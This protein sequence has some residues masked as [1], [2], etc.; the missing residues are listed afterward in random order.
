MAISLQ[1]DSN[2]PQGY[3]LV[4]GTAAATVRQDG[5]LV[6]P[7]L[8]ASGIRVTGNSTFTGT[9]STAGISVNGN[10]S[11]TGT[12][13]VS[14]II[15]NDL[16]TQTSA[17]I[18]SPVQSWQNVAASRTSGATY[19][20]TT[21]RPIMVSAGSLGSGS[22]GTATSATV[23]GVTV[24]NNATQQVNCSTG[25]SFIVPAGAT[26][27]VSATLPWAFFSELR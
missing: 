12:T 27:S 2:L 26:Y 3:I 24:A 20:N 7:S 23:N 10:I 1:A 8:S 19:T 9:L 21:G 5:T 14:G 15:F 16:S 13:S 25:V 22:T 4:N 17:P 6:V 18:G 11:S